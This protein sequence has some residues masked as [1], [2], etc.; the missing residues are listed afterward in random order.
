MR[1]HQCHII[2]ILLVFHLCRSDQSLHGGLPW[3]RAGHWTVFCYC[4]LL[5][6]NLVSVGPLCSVRPSVPLFHWPHSMADAPLRYR[7]I[8]HT[9]ARA[10]GNVPQRLILPAERCTDASCGALAHP[11]EALRVDPASPSGCTCTQAVCC[12]RTSV[13]KQNKGCG[14]TW[15]VPL[16]FAA[17]SHGQ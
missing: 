10:M 16:C 14:D 1:E 2:V 7:P 3:L 6:C 5:S 15:Q 8:G 4:C 11:N 17:Q 12:A 13:L 9:F